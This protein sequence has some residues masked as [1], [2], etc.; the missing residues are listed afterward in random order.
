MQLNPG[1]MGRSPMIFLFHY[2][3]LI[4]CLLETKKSFGTEKTLR[5][6]WYLDLEID[7]KNI[8]ISAGCA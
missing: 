6:S 8:C 3:L 7:D 1:G 2:F 5:D 4:E